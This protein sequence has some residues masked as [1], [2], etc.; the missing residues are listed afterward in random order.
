MHLFK[1]KN[2]LSY[3]AII[4]TLTIGFTGCQPAENMFIKRGYIL[5]EKKQYE[6]ALTEYHRAATINPKNATAYYYLCWLSYKLKHYN[7]ASFYYQKAIE[8]K[9]DFAMAYYGLSEVY[10]ALGQIDKAK[11]YRLKVKEF[12]RKGH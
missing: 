3:L 2:I 6:K 11:E 12:F 7:Q 5:M 1:Q 9:S 8:L 4:S 10:Y